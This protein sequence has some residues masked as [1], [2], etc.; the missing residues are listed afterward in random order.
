MESSSGQRQAFP[1]WPA[2]FAGWN[3]GKN[4]E[5]QR[6]LPDA[7][8]QWRSGSGARPPCVSAQPERYAIKIEFEALRRDPS[9]AELM[10]GVASGATR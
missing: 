2:S 5:P 9:F 6:H 4:T 10:Q 1:Q 8:A 7:V 3:C